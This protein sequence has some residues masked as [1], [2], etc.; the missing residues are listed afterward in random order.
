MNVQGAENAP[1]PK[2]CTLKINKIP[3]FFISKY[4]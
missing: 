1:P 2:K 3:S 4:L